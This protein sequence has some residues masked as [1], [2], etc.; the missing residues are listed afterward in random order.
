MPIL[1]PILLKCNLHM[2]LH[3]IQ[4][5]ASNRSNFLTAVS[6]FSSY[7]TDPLTGRKMH[8]SPYC[9]PPQLVNQW[10]LHR[11]ASRNRSPHS[12]AVRS[13]RWSRSLSC[14]DRDRGICIKPA[15]SAPITNV[16]QAGTILRVAVTERVN[17]K[18]HY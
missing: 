12:S 14:C 10:Q 2:P 3:D 15:T 5:N 11:I 9:L 16:D 13:F 18:L 8:L 17:Q 1:I 4:K 7:F 6:I